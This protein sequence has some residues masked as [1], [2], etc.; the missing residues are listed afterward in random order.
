MNPFGENSRLTRYLVTVLFLVA[1]CTQTMAQSTWPTKPV[2]IVIPVPPGGSQDTLG[3]GAGAELTKIWGQ[4]VVVESR[5]GAGGITAAD[6]VAK[7]SADGYTLLMS[8]EVPLILTPL[9]HKTL[10]YDPAKDFIPVVTLAQS[11]SIVVAPASAPF[12]SMAEL[13]ATAK[14]KPGTINFASFGPGST[15]HL[16]TEDFAVQAGITLTHVPYKGG[17]EIMRGLMSSDINFAFTGLA[18]AVPLIKQ[19][20]IKAIGFA[21]EVRLPLFPEVPTVSETLPGFQTRAWFGWMA[22]AGTPRPVVDKI[23]ADVARVIANP[24]FKE[25]FLDS[26][27][28]A[29]YSLTPDQFQQL[30]TTTRAKYQ[31]L[32]KK[33]KLEPS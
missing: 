22:P 10:P 4:P 7:S 19:G 18:A 1:Y 30:V 12:N 11:S 31:V 2:R 28:L 15:S 9:L 13:I 24:S 20:R 27:G 5:P 17:A 26:A 32:V 3:R 23:A 29:P 16:N 33:L 8:D 6:A 14:V 25:K 21:G